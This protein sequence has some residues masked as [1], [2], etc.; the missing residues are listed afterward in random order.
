MIRGFMILLLCQLVGE[1]IARIL[2]LPVP[3][4]VVGMLVLWIGLSRRRSAPPWLHETGQGLLRH[5]PLLFV[6]AGVGI[7]V[8]GGLLQREWRPLL[9]TLISSTLVTMIVTAATMR[10]LLRRLR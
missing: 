4:P 9:I 3:G 7:M 2:A 5:F 8:H 10:F 6:P 1:I